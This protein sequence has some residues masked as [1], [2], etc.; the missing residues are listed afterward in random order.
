MTKRV[1]RSPLLKESGPYM[2]GSKANGEIY[3]SPAWPQ[4]PKYTVEDGGGP[5]LFSR[6]RLAADIAEFLNA[7]YTQEER[8]ATHAGHGDHEYV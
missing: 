8:D 1:R 4:C 2:V 6:L 3:I 5:G 7:P